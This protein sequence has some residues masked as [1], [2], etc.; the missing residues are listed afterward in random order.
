MW[1][2]T[3]R[4]ACTIFSKRETTALAYLCYGLVFE[5]FHRRLGSGGLAD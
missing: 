2:S 5:L 3:S 4:I 1:S